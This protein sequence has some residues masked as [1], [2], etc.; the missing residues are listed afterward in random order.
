MWVRGLWYP[1]EELRSVQI[2]LVI[3]HGAEKNVKKSI[4]TSMLVRTQIACVIPAV[5]ICA[6][7]ETLRPE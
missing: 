4:Q 6:A 7:C 5:T 2:G 1:H 3:L